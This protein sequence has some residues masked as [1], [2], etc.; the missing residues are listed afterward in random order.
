[1]KVA[2]YSEILV[3]A[4]CYRYIEQKTFHIF[5]ADMCSN[6]LKNQNFNPTS[7]TITQVYILL[8]TWVDT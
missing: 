6:I 3:S 4:S 8:D 2:L 1:M 7:L 5:N